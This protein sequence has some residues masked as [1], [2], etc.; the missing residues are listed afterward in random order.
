MHRP[1][2]FEAVLNGIRAEVEC[3]RWRQFY[4]YFL[5]HWVLEL[6]RECTNRIFILFKWWCLSI[7]MAS[8]QI[9]ACHERRKSHIKSRWEGVS[10]LLLLC[11]DSVYEQA[12]NV[13]AHS[14]LG[15]SSPSTLIFTR[16]R[17]ALHCISSLLFS[18][19]DCGQATST[20]G[21]AV[22][23]SLSRLLCI[24]PRGAPVWILY[25]QLLMTL[26]RPFFTKMETGCTGESLR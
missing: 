10:L 12:S 2:G 19:I 26:Q 22:D 8:K 3:R 21:S 24:W 23:A 4:A 17:T 5:E 11:I 18:R 6:G 7:A 15:F 25:N 14:Q 20:A 13:D 1:S 16:L 9:P